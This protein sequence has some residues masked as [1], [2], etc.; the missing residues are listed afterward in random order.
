MMLF[1]SALSSQMSP[2]AAAAADNASLSVSSDTYT[3]HTSH[4]T[5]F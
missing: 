4:V 5:V 3:Q 2:A 1:V